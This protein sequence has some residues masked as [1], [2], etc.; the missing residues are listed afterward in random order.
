MGDEKSKNYWIFSNKPEGAYGN[1]DWDMASVLRTKH[2]YLLEN[3][4]NRSYIKSGDLVYMRIYGECFLGKFTVGGNWAFDPKSEDKHNCK[5]GY[6][7]IGDDLIIWKRPLPQNLILHDISNKNIRSRISYI[8][9]EDTVKIDTAQ[10]IYEKLGY[11]GANGE[12]LVLE[13]GLEEAIKPNLSSLGL[14]LADPKIQQ[15]FSMGPGVGRSD[16]ICLNENN[17]YVIL[18]LKRG[19]SSDEA[20]GQIL[21]YVGW[22]KE[23]I[24]E[25]EQNVSGWIITGDYDEQLRLAASAADIKIIR[26]RIM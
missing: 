7:P 10:L 18:E 3:E 14:N 22:V 20:I 12:I 2:Y 21:R 24:A 23:N 16:L 9:R 15:Q 5:A 19:F 17:D 1:R 4:N 6:F 13:R 11:G 8:T 25:S 26:I